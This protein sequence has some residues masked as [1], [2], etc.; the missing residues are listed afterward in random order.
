MKGV[1]LITLLTISLTR[2]TGQ[3]KLTYELLTQRNGLSDNF[4]T[5]IV[6]DKVGYFWIGTVSGLNRFDGHEF[7][8]FRGD[9]S[10]KN[11]LQGNCISSLVLDHDNLLWIG[12]IGEGLN[13]YNSSTGQ[14]KNYDSIP[15]L[16]KSTIHTIYVGKRNEI[17]IGYTGGFCRFNP[18]SGIAE[19]FSLAPYINKGYSQQ[20]KANYN[21]VFGFYEDKRGL[22]WI[23][24]L[25]GLYQFNQDTKQLR[26]ERLVADGPGV[27]RDDWTQP[28]AID[29]DR[30]NIYFPSSLGIRRFNM[31][32]K[33]SSVPYRWKKPIDDTKTSSIAMVSKS[34]NEF[35]I[36]TESELSIYNTKDDKIE[37][38][39]ATK[40]LANYSRVM[41]L[42]PDHL[43]IAS[44][45][46]LQKVN[47]TPKLLS[48]HPLKNQISQ[49]SNRPIPES[50]SS[51]VII[52]DFFYDTAL[53]KTY[54]ATEYGAG[55]LVYDST[56]KILK[57]FLCKK[58]TSLSTVIS[59]I[60]NL[61]TTY[62][63]VLSRDYIQLFNKKTEEWSTSIS[64][65]NTTNN[66]RAYFS[67]VLKTQDGIWIGSLNDG[68][69]LFSPE[70]QKLQWFVHDSSNPN[71]FPSNKI[72]GMIEDPWK[73]V[74]FV[75]VDKGVIIYDPQKKEF[76]NLNDLNTGVAI[77]FKNLE[78]IAISKD[79]IVWIGSFGI[80]LTPI[81]LKGK[82]SF[83]FASQIQPAFQG[84]ID[85]L[86]VDNDNKL[87]AKGIQGVFIV[88]GSR[89]ALKYIDK[90]EYGKEF[91]YLIQ[92]Q[93]GKILIGSRYGFYTIDEKSLFKNS[94]ATES[95][96]I[97]SLRINGSE[98]HVQNPEGPNTINLPYSRNSILVEFSSIDFCDTPLQQYAYQ[99]EGLEDTWN[100]ASAS[101]KI[102]NYP[103]LPGGNYTFKIKTVNEDGTSGKEKEMIKIHIAT[104]FWKLL[105]F[106]A[107]VAIVFAIALYYLIR[108][109][110]DHL[111][112]EQSLKKELSDIQLVA[113]RTQ[114]NPHFIFNS[115]NSIQGLII[116]SDVSKATQF[117]A[118]F[119][120]LIRKVLENSERQL[121]PLS[122]EIETL[123]LYLSTEAIRFEG[124]FR[125]SISADQSLSK[126]EIPSM[127]I[128]PIIENVI[129][130]GLKQKWEIGEVDIE[131]ILI[132]INK[133]SCVI[134][135]NGR[136][137]SEV[138][139]KTLSL[140][141]RSVNLKL[142]A[143]RLSLLSSNSY[144]NTE[145]IYEGSEK[146][147]NK[148]IVVFDLKP[149]VVKGNNLAIVQKMLK[150][151]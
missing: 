147:G 138:S 128:Q 125:Y 98:V 123:E 83:S 46:G 71:S 105:W 115:L 8:I 112:R 146:V 109:R 136:E 113:L 51:N 4:V 142:T 58:N 48:F 10:K 75:T 92:T 2:L 69:R 18:R 5:S 20:D 14:F 36:K 110:L 141:E 133:I 22:I 40:F 43:W 63:L 60:F 122:E 62:L 73:R 85:Q 89:N 117:T 81:K 103:H 3:S 107:V 120:K 34:K 50:D 106:R 24:S 119:S 61:D 90:S 93:D 86:I 11:S 12:L 55:L 49:L 137:Q 139:L 134:T 21:S 140:S 148:V 65:G 64:S 7:K 100:Y 74:W 28:W 114:M 32:S 25:D 13:S 135:D 66:M 26:P 38:S 130:E 149:F 132:D 145:E 37:F 68:A 87:W 52:S 44:N 144:I 96:I 126:I 31:I 23:S 129:W 99:L 91:D 17:W 19:S 143:S 35:W 70:S 101:Q 78:T 6:Q 127:V 67:D 59:K 39:D 131:F 104:P 57:N 47:L 97:N 76:T 108:L 45:I 116:R 82:F 80:G 27:F 54:I 95:I 77:N 151:N 79:S 30:D 94:G 88:N 15:D 72:R 111:L 16:P 53:R 56:T 102:A 42:T 124:K 9:P 150:N 29:E 121:I 1:F 118:R 33:K 84:A 41:L